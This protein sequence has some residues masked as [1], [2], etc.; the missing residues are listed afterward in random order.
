MTN[1]TETAVAADNWESRPLHELLHRIMRLN[2][3]LQFCKGRA[4]DAYAPTQTERDRLIQIYSRRV[5]LPT[6]PPISLPIR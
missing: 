1:N 4:A 5:K 6:T 3:A 2:R